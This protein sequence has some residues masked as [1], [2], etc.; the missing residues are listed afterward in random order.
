MPELPK[1]ASAALAPKLPRISRRKILYGLAGGV[2]LGVGYVVWPRHTKLNLVARDDETI[3]SGWIKIGKDGRV[4][5]VVPQAEMGQ[6]VYTS[7]AMIV[8]E[9][10]GA[11]WDSISVEP[12]PLH[13]IYANKT[14]FHEALELLPGITQGVARRVVDT[15]VERN[16]FQITGGSTSVRGFH[17]T[18]RLAAAVARDMLR[19]AAARNWNID[20]TLTESNDSAISSGERRAEFA[21][22][23]GQIEPGD[24]K[25]SPKF[26]S[27]VLF[28]IVGK[29][30]PRIDIPA[31]TDGSAGFGMDV[32][33]PGMVYAA[34]RSGP[35]N[36]GLLL[37]LDDKAALKIP[38]VIRTVK[39]KT[40]FAVVADRYW[41]A[42]SALEKVK[43]DFNFRSSGNIDS[44]WVDGNLA[45][46]L[47][48]GKAHVY[49]SDGD[50][51]E[52]ISAAATQLTVEYRVP[53]LAHAALEPLNATVRVNADDSVEIWAPTQSISL[54]IS[55]VARALAMPEKNIRVYPTLIGGGF[56]IKVETEA[57]E[58]AALCARAVG[59]PVQLIWSREQDMQQDRFRPG[60]RARLSGSVNAQGKMTAFAARLASQSASGSSGDRL[61]PSIASHEPDIASVQGMF[62]AP[63]DFGACHVEHAMIKLPVPVGFWRSVGHSS[64]AFFLESFIDELAFKAGI[65]PVQFRLSLLKASPRHVH[66]LEECA[67]LA[68]APV[69]GRGRGFAIH[70]SFGSICAQAVDVAITSSGAADVKRVVCV[71]DCGRAIHPDTIIGQMEGGIIF[72]LTA[73]LFGKVEFN[74][75]FASV[76]NLDDYPLLTLAQAP[77]IDVHIVES[78]GALGG[79]GEVGVPPIAPAV[80]N[81]IFNASGIRVRTLPLA[82]LKFLSAAAIKQAQAMEAVQGAATVVEPAP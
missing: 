6:G 57:V 74:Q 22:L 64:N 12:A 9:E 53:Y 10:L 18:L 54:V 41:T 40:W 5:V 50:A 4:V 51:K 58:Q 38:G 52:I 45:T 78:G 56:G 46:A 21:S 19:K 61:M 26:K 71:V 13:P 55:N 43:V 65:H 73:A 76:K 29:N 20:W 75:G 48:S 60:A 39:G 28:S 77:E 68:G 3:L 44:K 80:T 16:A 36:E 7:L 23:L 72:G 24:A 62:N 67:R 30:V 14:G 70:E 15:V 49:Q 31:K 79:I 8:A 1:T 33:L 59:K 82:G 34:V 66:V 32:R 47:A 27:A 69:E 42:K 37:D 35:M 81:A 17:D 11:R 2:V 25:G 63:Y